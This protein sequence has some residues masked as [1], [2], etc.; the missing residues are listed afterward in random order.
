MTLMCPPR[1]RIGAVRREIRNAPVGG[2]QKSHEP[3]VTRQEARAAAKKVAELKLKHIEDTVLAS[4]MEEH[5]NQEDA[6]ARLFEDVEAS[7]IDRAA[8]P[9]G[10]EHLFTP[11]QMERIEELLV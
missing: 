5:P 8:R 3:L 11:T 4:I 10:D 1:R 2:S 7:P 9:M 6:L